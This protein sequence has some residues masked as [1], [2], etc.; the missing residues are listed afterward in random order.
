M[1]LLASCAAASAAADVLGPAPGPVY[2]AAVSPAY[3][4]TGFYIGAN[5]WLKGGFGG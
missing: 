2:Q 3:N 1:S 4:W 5:H